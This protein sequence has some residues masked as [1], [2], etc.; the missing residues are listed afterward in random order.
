M[1]INPIFHGQ[2]AAR[3]AGLC[4][5]AVASGS[6]LLETFPGDWVGPD[7]KPLVAPLAYRFCEPLSTG[8]GR[9]LRGLFGRFWQT[10]VDML[11]LPVWGLAIRSN[12]E[13]SNAAI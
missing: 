2:V 8:L 6:F 12:K 1:F 3:R 4:L 11:G 7:A 9:G 10:H 13:I 5:A